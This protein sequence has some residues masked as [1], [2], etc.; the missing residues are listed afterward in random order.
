M[1]N[2]KVNE[3]VTEKL[4]KY[5]VECSNDNHS[6]V[7]VTEEFMAD[8]FAKLL[9]VYAAGYDVSE[10]PKTVETTFYAMAEELNNVT[11]H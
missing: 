1:N 2:E 4:Q 5:F 11:K 8:A 10:F 9:V 3:F 6:K 7:E